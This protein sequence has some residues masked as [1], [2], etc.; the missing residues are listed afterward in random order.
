MMLSEIKSGYLAN[1]EMFILAV[2][3]CPDGFWDKTCGDNS[4]FWKEA[5]HCIFWIHNFLGDGKKRFE[6]KPFGKDVDPRLFKPASNRCSK[7]EILNFAEET[8]RFVHD[9]F[10]EMSDSDLLCEDGYGDGHRNVLHRLIYGLRHGQHHTGKL[11]GYLFLSG[12]D[13]DPWKD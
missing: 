9:V 6:R 1:L 11:T 8:K 5:Y 12:V 3:N 10:A 13:Y 4:P 2:T 7:E